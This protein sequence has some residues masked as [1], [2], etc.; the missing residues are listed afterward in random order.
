MLNCHSPILIVWLFTNVNNTAYCILSNYKVR[1]NAIVHLDSVHP[2]QL[3]HTH[4]HTHTHTHTHTHP[5]AHTHTHTHTHTNTH[6][7][8][9]SGTHTHTVRFCGLTVELETPL[10]HG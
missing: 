1:L 10:K 2:S 6:T 3:P 4:K 7:H 9:Q 5:H 8:R